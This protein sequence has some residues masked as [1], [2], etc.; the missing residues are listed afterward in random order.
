MKEGSIGMIRA[1]NRSV[2]LLLI[3]VVTSSLAFAQTIKKRI[4]FS[5]PVV[6]NGTVV[7]KGTYDAVFDDQANE[8]RIVKDRKV[9]A[10]APARLEKRDLPGQAVFVSREEGGANVLVTIALK[11]NNQATIVNGESKSTSAQ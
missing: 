8:L 1:I 11:G 2:V 3:G 7:K 4:T 6:V 10:K 5:A 9:I